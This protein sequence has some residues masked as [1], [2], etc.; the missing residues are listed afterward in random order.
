MM[1]LVLL[2]PLLTKFGTQSVPTTNKA[3]TKA[4]TNHILETGRCLASVVFMPNICLNGK[5]SA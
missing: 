5:I 3:D 4:S 1:T 2:W